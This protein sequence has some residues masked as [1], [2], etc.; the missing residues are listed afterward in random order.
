MSEH[1]HRSAQRRQTTD[2]VSD[3]GHALTAR[4]KAGSR[5]AIREAILLYSPQ[6]LARARSIVGPA[7]AEDVVQD[8]WLAVL[9]KIDGFE[10]RAALG[11]WLLRIVSNR[12]ISFIRS[13]ARE[14]GA[15]PE[16]EG[17][18]ESDWFDERGRWAAPPIAWHAGSPDDLLDAAALQDCLDK[19]LQLLPDQQR[20]VLVMRDMDQHSYEDICNELNLSASNV[21]VLLHRAR[22]RL[23]KM[24]DGFQET[25]EC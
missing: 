16:S 18:P 10:E 19:H 2:G 22:M 6:M 25:G 1:G 4:L 8:A 9:N 13:R 24:V 7:Y 12:A 15:T 14:S 11:T 5:E 21:R 20:S 23:M 17:A 3:G